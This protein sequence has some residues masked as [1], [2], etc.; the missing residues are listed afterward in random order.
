MASNTRKLE[1]EETA[2]EIV[3]G[4]P[5]RLAKTYNNEGYWQSPEE[6][7]SRREWSVP[8]GLR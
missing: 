3:K 6:S 4:N 7:V 2:K 8:P 1:E 5:V